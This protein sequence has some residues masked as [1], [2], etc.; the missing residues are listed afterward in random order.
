MIF[1][2]EAILKI[3]VMGFLINGKK[4]YLLDSW[5]VLD[6]I[7][8]A[9]SLPNFFLDS[10]FSLVKVLRVARIIRP[11]RLVKHSSHL[12]IAVQAL[13]KAIPNILRLQ[14]VV[15]FVMFMIS[16]LMTSLLSGQMFN[17][18]LSHTQL[19]VP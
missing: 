14:V 16:I 11:L 9:F 1:C 10:S 4:S 19:S 15:M 17:C 2:I 13:L 3:I 7:I 8:V 18:N 5:N 6:F 12:K